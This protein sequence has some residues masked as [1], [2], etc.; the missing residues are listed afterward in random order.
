MTDRVFL[1]QRI[2]HPA[3]QEITRSRVGPV[4]NA[5]HQDLRVGLE[6]NAQLLKAS[7]ADGRREAFDDLAPKK[8]PPMSGDTGGLLVLDL[9]FADSSTLRIP[10]GKA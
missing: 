10:Q 8:K 6:R 7:A 9:L 2:A 1:H 3:V 4:K 5:Q